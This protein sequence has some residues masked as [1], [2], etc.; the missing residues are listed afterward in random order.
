MALALGQAASVEQSEPSNMND[1]VTQASTRVYRENNEL[2]YIIKDHS[3]LTSLLGVQ[4][5]GAPFGKGSSLFEALA[6]NN[7]MCIFACKD[8]NKLK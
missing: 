3:S 1:D 4:I 7:F 5:K 6:L 2:E 8:K